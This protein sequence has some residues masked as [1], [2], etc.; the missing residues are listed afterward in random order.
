MLD[1]ICNM[2]VSPERSLGPVVH[3]GQ[4]YYFCSQQCLQRFSAKPFTPSVA[5]TFP[6]EVAPAPPRGTPAAAPT[7]APDRAEGNLYTCPMHPE[8]VQEGP[9]SCPICGMALEPM[10]IRAE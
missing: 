10:A 5:S 3:D 8:V 1:P 9:G 4:A 2:S 6:F 7:V